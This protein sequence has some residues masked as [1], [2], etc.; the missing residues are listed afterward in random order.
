MN[1]RGKWWKVI[2][3]LCSKGSLES[4][5]LCAAMNC[6]G[7]V[8]CWRIRCCA[9]VLGKLKF[10]R[11]VQEIQED[12]HFA[13]NPTSSWRFSPKVIAVIVKPVSVDC[14]A[15]N[16]STKCR[17]LAM[18]LQLAATTIIIFIHIHTIS[19]YSQGS[20]FALM[21]SGWT[22]AISSGVQPL[23]HSTRRA[24]KPWPNVFDISFLQ[25][26]QLFEAGFL[27]DRVFWEVVLLCLA[28]SKAIY[29]RLLPLEIKASESPW[30]VTVPSSS[31]EACTSEHA[32]PTRSNPFHGASSSNPCWQCYNANSWHLITYLTWTNCFMI[33][34]Q[35]QLHEYCILRLLAWTTL[36]HPG[37][38]FS[39]TFR[40]SAMGFSLSKSVYARAAR[41]HGCNKLQDLP[42]LLRFELSSQCHEL[43]V[44]SQFEYSLG[45]ILIHF[46]SSPWQVSW[47]VL[48][49]IR[50]LNKGPQC[51]SNTARR[52]FCKIVS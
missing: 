13:V 23:K 9:R 15:E 37:T 6:L 2:A 39:G 7:S 26:S 12:Q 32:I 52:R 19:Y 34:Q 11:P 4:H 33:C 28:G 25:D 20:P 51:L 50:K 22:P 14:P 43:L 3:R 31:K 44:S 38:L 1:L 17:V 35:N 16:E 45:I 46:A 40:S 10:Q 27:A 30:N 41:V 36:K 47:W 18:L 42:P 24:T 48:I 49:K 29:I 21:N 8:A 5:H